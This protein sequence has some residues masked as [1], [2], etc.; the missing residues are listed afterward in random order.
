MKR[1]A[2]QHSMNKPAMGEVVYR[3]TCENPGCGFGFDLK[4]TRANVG[5]LGRRISCPRCRRPGGT[6]KRLQRLASRTFSSRLQFPNESA[7]AIAGP[8]DAA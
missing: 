4:I 3:T 2:T 6:L 1:A 8:G 7:R 5:I